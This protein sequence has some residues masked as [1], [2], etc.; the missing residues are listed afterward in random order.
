MMTGRYE[1]V[2]NAL[3]AC[4]VDTREE[5]RLLTVNGGGSKAVVLVAGTQAA[6]PFDL[7]EAFLEGAG[8]F[9][10]RAVPYPVQFGFGE[11]FRVTTEDKN[12]K[13][14]VY[15]RWED[16]WEDLGGR[17]QDV[18]RCH[19]EVPD[20]ML[21]QAE[22]RFLLLDEDNVVRLSELAA[23]CRGF[24]VALPAGAGAPGD[25]VYEL[26]Q[27]IRDARCLP[28]RTGILLNHTETGLIVPGLPRMVKAWLGVEDAQKWNCSYQDLG[29]ENGPGMMLKEA[30]A[31]VLTRGGT[32]GSDAQ[33][34]ARLAANCVGRALEKLDGAQ[35]ELDREI[36]A[37]EAAAQ[38]VRKA[39]TGFRAYAENRGATMRFRLNKT[40]TEE[41]EGDIDGMIQLLRDKLPEMLR[42]VV[43]TTPDE[44]QAKQDMK[45]VDEYLEAVCADY[46]STLTNHIA[47]S[48][49]DTV[50]DTFHSALVEYRAIVT[51]TPP[52]LEEQD[53][54]SD[55]EILN[56]I[57]VDLGGYVDP[58]ATTIGAFAGKGVSL[59]LILLSS[60]DETGLARSVYYVVRERLENTVGRVVQGV[61]DAVMPAGSYANHLAQSLQD[62]VFDPKPQ[63]KISKLLGQEEE[64]PVPLAQ[65]LK[66]DLE[67]NILPV[68]E[69]TAKQQYQGM[70]DLACGA[71][72]RE[73][74]DTLAR[75]D[76]LADQ[77]RRLLQQAETL[78]SLLAIND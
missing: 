21:K 50:K 59:M 5:E 46:I 29:G 19:I 32:E 36:G 67:V 71:L 42:E 34:D 51:N 43:D 74:T 78:Q 68:A 2:L 73:E 61:V 69:C 65:K 40:Q 20:I 7:A 13:E 37:L 60:L 53:A 25:E 38:R 55:A 14:H 12:G 56:S 39:Q 28:Q 57:Q 9:G 33:A 16:L 10:K 63:G 70:V 6:R 54:R 76:T 26:C 11:K 31:W 47:A 17:P 22:L 15:T 8:D 3:R 52:T 35:K 72:G 23:D 48:W 64:T 62:Q 75:R 27:W 77:K 24:M 4:Q 30:V 18:F 66:N 1:D 45:L 44:K 41:L 58:T 49:Q